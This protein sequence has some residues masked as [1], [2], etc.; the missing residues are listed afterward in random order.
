MSQSQEK[1]APK[2]GHGHDDF[3]AE[4]IR[5]LPE[6]LPEG[7]RILWQGEPTWRQLAVNVFHIRALA[8]YFGVLMIWRA[9]TAAGDGVGAALG[10]GL[11]P[12]PFLLGSVL[13]L[14]VLATLIART[15]VYTV[16]NKRL[17][18]RFGL[19]LTKAINIPFRL[20]TSADMRPRAGG[21]GD[22]AIHLDPSARIG[23][24][25]LWPHARPWR[26][27]H[28][29]PML[30]GVPDAGAAASILASA[31][32]E[33]QAGDVED[34]VSTVQPDETLAEAPAVQAPSPRPLTP[35]AA[36]A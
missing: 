15:T 17:V 28:P 36:S 25:H 20:V 5:G 26:L 14:C 31:L 6:A 10:A 32:Q 23:Y 4:P 21:H 19:A 24:I 34:A 27:Q 9:S 16:T 35:I 3:A 30:R 8:I 7:E 33:A 18:M 11:A 29:Q 1:R 22:I 12:A 2:G 13:V